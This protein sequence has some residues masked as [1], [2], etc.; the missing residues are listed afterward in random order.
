MAEE[1]LGEK[2]ISIIKD[3]KIKPIRRWQ[4]KL[5]NIFVWL[6]ALIAF[7]FSSLSFSVLL[8]LLN[9]LDLSS[10]RDINISSWR[11]LL[12][13]LPFFWIFFVAAF[14][15]IIFVQVKHTKKGYLYPLWLII[16]GSFLGSIFLGS[17]MTKAGL[18]EKIDEILSYKTP[19]YQTVINPQMGFWSAPD[20]GR[21]LG[22]VLPFKTNDYVEVRDEKGVIWQVF[23][24]FNQEKILLRE[25]EIARFIGEKTGENEFFALKV[26]PYSAGKRM[27]QRQ[28]PRGQNHDLLLN[29]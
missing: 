28:A 11:L 25:N 18:G 13:T 19:L 21:L 9:N 22:V 1:K 27:F 14:I 3:R 12:N 15:I 26:L 7:L 8:F 16:T 6:L 2:I 23:L 5:K 10:S 24:N 29:R 4:F 17:V 20:K